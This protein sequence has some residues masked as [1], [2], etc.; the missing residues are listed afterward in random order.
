L[1]AQHHSVFCS[2]EVHVLHNTV[3]C[4][5]LSRFLVNISFSF[6]WYLGGILEVSWRYLGLCVIVITKEFFLFGATAPQSARASSFTRLLDHTQQ[7]TTVDRTPLD[8]WSALRRDLYLTT[9]NIHN[10]Q[11]SMPPVTFEPTISAGSRP[12]TDAFTKEWD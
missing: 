11:T 5:F 12:Q 8:E 4:V 1:L 3:M 6:A 10:R 9:Y 2:K 7:R